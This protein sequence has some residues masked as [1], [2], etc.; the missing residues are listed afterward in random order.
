[1][2]DRGEGAAGRMNLQIYGCMIGLTCEFGAVTDG[3]HVLYHCSVVNGRHRGPAGRGC[4]PW[5]PHA[6]VLHQ[7]FI[8]EDLVRPHHYAIRIRQF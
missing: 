2:Q 1:M 6:R 5:T 3:K 8:S 7:L 4:V